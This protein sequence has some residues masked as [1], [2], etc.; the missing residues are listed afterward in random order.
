MYV[1]MILKHLLEILKMF[2]N[3]PL[4]YENQQYYYYWLSSKQ[5]NKMEWAN[6]NNYEIEEFLGLKSLR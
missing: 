2:K 1:K 3:Y 5:L 4:L 6:Q